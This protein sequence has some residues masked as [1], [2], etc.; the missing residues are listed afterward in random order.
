M[1]DFYMTLFSN[2]SM[3]FHRDNKT[4]SFTVQLPRHM[5]LSGDWKVAL[6]EIQYPYSFFNVHDN[7][8]I[9]EIQSVKVTDELKTFL[10]DNKENV[11][12]SATE[13]KF[14]VITKVCDIES[15]FYSDITKLIEAVNESICK[16]WSRDGVVEF[17]FFIRDKKT[18]K[19]TA[20]PPSSK[21]TLGSNMMTSIRLFGRLALQ[22]GFIPGQPIN[23]TNSI[24]NH[25]ANLISGIPDK[26]FIYCDIVDTQICGDI[27]ANILRSVTIDS[28]LETYFGKPCSKEFT[29]LQYV[30]VHLKHFDSIRIDIREITGLLLP[31]RC[32]T[33]SVKLHFKQF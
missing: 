22:L 17:D 5:S 15:G 11:T 7:Q 32:G 27:W 30:P 29:Q 12:S 2:S 25:T 6:T 24:G 21:E 20:H 9:I 26:M 33:S 16:E 4:S 1:T 23:N 13:S 28:P 3:G 14:T 31:F 10:K 19:L 8:N 18:N